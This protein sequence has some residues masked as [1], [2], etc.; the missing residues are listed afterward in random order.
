MQD[1]YDEVRGCHERVEVAQEM[2]RQV[3]L[4]NFE[5]VA[6]EVILNVLTE[7]WRRDVAGMLI[8]DYYWE[9]YNVQASGHGI[10]DQLEREGYVGQSRSE[11]GW[12]EHDWFT[13]LKE[14]GRKIVEC[15][16]PLASGV[17]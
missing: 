5:A 4:D 8:V 11:T 6:S 14:K 15:E 3:W 17:E 12:G 9:F 1:F 16:I 13:Y 10:L 2:L 7:G